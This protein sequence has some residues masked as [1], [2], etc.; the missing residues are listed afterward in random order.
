M[1]HTTFLENTTKTH[2]HD[3]LDNKIRHSYA[4]QQTLQLIVEI[5]FFNEINESQQPLQ[6][7]TFS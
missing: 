3:R 5:N 2:N 6:F 4:I 7:L 1:L